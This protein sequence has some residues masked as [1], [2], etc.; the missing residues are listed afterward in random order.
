MKDFRESTV[1]I[2]RVVEKKR[3]KEKKRKFVFFVRLSLALTVY[4]GKDNN[5]F[6]GFPG[7]SS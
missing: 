3:R 2:E 6:L 4:C 7:H 1:E 5:S